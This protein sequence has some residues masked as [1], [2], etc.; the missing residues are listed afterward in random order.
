MCF[1]IRSTLSSELSISHYFELIRIKEKHKRDFYMKECISSNLHVRELQK[2]KKRQLT[3][4][5]FLIY[6]CYSGKK[7]YE[8]N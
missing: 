6:F 4:T 1:P 2:N 8:R 3:P 5:T 7:I